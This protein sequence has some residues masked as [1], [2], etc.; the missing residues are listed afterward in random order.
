M[1]HSTDGRQAARTLEA[2]EVRYRRLFET[3]QDGI[4]IL[5][6]DSGRIVDSNPFLG[7]LLGYSA[8]ELL[9]K[10]LWEIGL[11]QDIEANRAGFRQLQEEGY[12]RYEDLPLETKAGRRASVEFVSNVYREE[13]RQVI[14]CNIRDIGDRKRAEDAVRA[15]DRRRDEYL[16]MLAHELRNP[17]APLRNAVEVMR[18]KG[19][20]DPDVQ[21]ARGLVERQ[22]NLLT[23]LVDDLMDVSRIRLGKINL[24]TEPVNLAGVVALAVEI[25]RPLIDAGGHH[26]EVSL[27]GRPLWVAGDPT[28]LAQVLSNLLNNAAKYTGT[29]G[30][31]TLTAE[32]SGGEAVLRVRDTGVGIAPDML[33]RVFEM[34]TQV[35]GS[36]GRS[37]GGLGIGLTLV[38]SLV[39]MHGGSVEACSE[40][41]GCGSEFV[42]RLPLLE[43]AVPPA[44]ADVERQWPREGPP[45]SVLVVDDNRDA[46]DSLADLLRLAGHEVCVAY[47]GPAALDLA[48]VR[49]PDVVLMDIGMPGMDGLEVARRLRQELGLMQTLLVALTGCAGDSDR[50]RS[51]EA[52][53]NAHL[54]KPAQ[55]LDLA[56]LLSRPM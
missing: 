39:E 52:G 36:V 21:Q 32:P 17:L 13:S 14:Q 56:C 31:L 25:S 53:F 4:L 28:R 48:R 49:P 51:Q 19:A 45:W 26:L 9:G 38:R 35:Q 10:E 3:A 7:A 20:G 47:D 54:V 34:F 29:G 16:V 6:G 40:G 37:A 11:F 1:N 41:L 22:V 23:R 8:D 44:A 18:L 46:A 33:S 55:P 24:R 50:L 30:S 2:S 12:A 43:E 5:D 15:A 27:P 42:V